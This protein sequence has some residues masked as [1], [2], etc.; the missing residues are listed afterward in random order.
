MTGLILEILW[1]ITT[2]LWLGLINVW[3]L[4]YIILWQLLWLIN[5]N[6]HNTTVDGYKILHHQKDGWNPKNN[7]INNH[8]DNWCRISQPS[9]VF[10]YL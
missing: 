7:G 3:L 6:Y 1:F 8:L 2:L 10:L 5:V 9:T 4:Q